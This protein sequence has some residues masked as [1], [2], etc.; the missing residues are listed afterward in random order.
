[1]WLVAVGLCGLVVN[2]DVSGLRATTQFIFA[3][4]LARTGESHALPELDL[5][6]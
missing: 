5:V 4:E 2:T 3:C 6:R 1:M